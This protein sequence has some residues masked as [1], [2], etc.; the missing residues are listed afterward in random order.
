MIEFTKYTLDNG[1]RLI[2]HYDSATKMV[3]LNLLYDVGSKDEEA[4]STGLAHLMEH[5]M[6]TGSANAPSYD[7]PLQA[8]GGVSN[9]WTNVDMTNYYETLPAHNIETGLWAESDRLVSLTLSEGSIK[10]Q[11]DVVMEEFKQRCLN[12]PYGDMSHLSH[13]LA[14]KSHPYLWPAIG[15]ELNHI[16]D[17]TRDKIVSFYRKFYSVN[18]L[19]MCISGNITAGD[20]IK[21]VDKWFGDIAPCVSLHS[22]N[23]PVEPQ[24]TEHR[25]VEV[26]RDVPQDV[27][28]QVYHMPG[29]NDQAYPVCDLLSDVLA[30]GRSS[31]FHQNILSKTSALTEVDAAIEG[32]IDP[33]LF[34]IRAKLAEGTTFAQAE[35][36]IQNEIRNIIVNGVT[37]YEL[38]KCLNKFHAASLFD[39]IGYRE[40]ATKLCLFELLGDAS[41]ANYEVDRYR[42]VSTDDLVNVANSLFDT[43]NCSS[44]YYKK[45]R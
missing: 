17:V 44:V 38:D 24:Q 10:N 27:L 1:L 43:N 3:A 32:T 45:S 40:K 28:Y 2:H 30:N 8:A 23:L 31:R 16:K 7:M 34:I 4:D 9:A 37:Q 36:L 29:R 5:L 11:K 20:A 35:E 42:K 22:R 26:T 15:K 12:K 6:F 25:V 33:G 18:N 41:L 19:I 39:N 13:E 14:Y 21:L